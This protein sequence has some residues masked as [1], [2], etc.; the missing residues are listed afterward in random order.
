MA[1]Q[2]VL[3]TG[4]AGFLGINLTRYLIARGD[5]IT[6][7]DIADFD[8]AV[9]AGPGTAC[10]GD[11]RDQRAVETAM[12]GVDRGPMRGRP[13]ALLAGGH[14]HDR[15]DG[16]R[17]VLEAALRTASQRVVHISS[18]AVYGI[19]DHHPLLE[20]DRLD[21]VGPYG[22]PRSRPRWWRSNTARRAWSCRSSGRSRSSVRSGSASSRCSTTGRSTAATSR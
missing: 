17:V 19:P 2:R 22:R 13:A 9:H 7:L 8:Y 21:G 14:L 1:Q 5:A 18:T 10:S 11:I 12:A 20:N 3:I 16:T 4:G 15:C 6:S